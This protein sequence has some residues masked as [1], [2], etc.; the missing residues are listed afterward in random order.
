MVRV[1][2]LARA[3]IAKAQGVSREEQQVQ[4]LFCS[5]EPSTTSKCGMPSMPFSLTMNRSYPH[6]RELGAFAR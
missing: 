3:I 6:E 1:A 5:V 2:A 4:I